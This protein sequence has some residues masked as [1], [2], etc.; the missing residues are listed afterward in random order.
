MKRI[1][2]FFIFLFI[3]FF[4]VSC[5]PHQ[6]FVIKILNYSSKTIAVCGAYILPETKLPEGQLSTTK[7]LPQKSGFIYDSQINDIG[8][9]RYKTEKVTIFFLD[10]HVFQTV[11]WDTIRKYDMVLKRYEINQEDFINT[12]KFD[13]KLGRGLSYP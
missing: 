8:L 6:H 4:V 3:T 10:D 12:S 7:I 2:F 13:D 9:R 11:P 1:H 5:I